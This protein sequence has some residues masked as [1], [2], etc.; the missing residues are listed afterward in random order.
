MGL[1]SA[2]VWADVRA[3]GGVRDL[4]VAGSWPDSSPEEVDHG[5]GARWLRVSLH[6]TQKKETERD[7][8]VKEISE[9][10]EQVSSC[11][12]D[13]YSRK[14]NSKREIENGKAVCI[15]K[16]LDSSTV[17]CHLD[18]CTFWLG[19]D[20]SSKSRLSKENVDM[21]LREIVKR[22]TIGKEVVATLVMESLCSGLRELEG[23]GK[24]KNMKG[25]LLD[26]EDTP[27]P[28]IWVE[29]DMFVLADDA[30]MLLERAASELLPSKDEK[31]PQN[32]L[33]DG[34][35]EDFS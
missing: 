5:G 21:I 34:S 2:I 31:G 18:F 20:Q 32:H 35:A 25:K 23:R 33:K 28:I 15:R 22:F 4:L 19:V 10:F 27:P 13:T 26:G 12:V 7:G 11:S 16:K 17:E 3:A 24:T 29:K 14:R 9:R 8:D 6:S 1:F 30:L